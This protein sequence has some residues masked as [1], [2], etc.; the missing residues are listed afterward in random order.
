MFKTEEIGNRLDFSFQTNEITQKKKVSQCLTCNIVNYGLV[1]ND[2]QTFNF[3]LGNMFK[4]EEIGY[5][6]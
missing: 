2:L 6:I 1:L 5:E 4:T 3:H